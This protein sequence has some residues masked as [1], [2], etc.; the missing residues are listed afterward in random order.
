MWFGDLLTIFLQMDRLDN[1]KSELEK[2][3]P[4]KLSQRAYL[5]HGCYADYY[6]KKGETPN[7]LLEIDLAIAAC[8]NQYERKYLEQKKESILMKEREN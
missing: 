4:Q 8:S 6:E 5:Y 7:A 1:A 2:I 3:N